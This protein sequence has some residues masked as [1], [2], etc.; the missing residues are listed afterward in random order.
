LLVAAA[1]RRSRHRRPRLAFVAPVVATALMLA[2]VLGA[3]CATYDIEPDEPCRQAGYSIASRTFACT[4]DDQLANARYRRFAGAYRCI[5]AEATPDTF[6]CSNALGDRTCAQVLADGDDLDAWLGAGAGCGQV[7]VRA[8]G[9]PLPN[10]SSEPGSLDESPRCTQIVQAAALARAGC[11][12]PASADFAANRELT[13][14]RLDSEFAC[15]EPDLDAL[16]PGAPRD[17][18]QLLSRCV[19]SVEEAGTRADPDACA[20]GTDPF[21]RGLVGGCEFL[22]LRAR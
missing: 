13:R 5:A 3:G 7:L 6:Y 9:T 21:F 19:E 20:K 10:A 12:P 11:S 16:P 2:P 15:R 14:Q 18:D 22:F 4:G 8:D 1:G 17:A